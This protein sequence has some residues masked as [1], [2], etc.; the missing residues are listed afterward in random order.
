MSH[1][2]DIHLVEFWHFS[3]WSC[4][5]SIVHIQKVSIKVKKPKR[6][7]TDFI[8]MVA[9]ISRNE[10]PFWSNCQQKNHSNHRLILFINIF[11]QMNWIKPT[12]FCSGKNAKKTNAFQFRRKFWQV[13]QNDEHNTTLCIEFKCDN[14]ALLARAITVYVTTCSFIYSEIVLVCFFHTQSISFTFVASL[15]LF[16]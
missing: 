2:C 7:P 4:W 6:C 12:D 1:F 9:V 8:C 15:K 11:C 13:K 5:K 14:A 16:V 3:N 10:S